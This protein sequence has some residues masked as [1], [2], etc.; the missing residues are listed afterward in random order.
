MSAWEEAAGTH[1]FSSYGMLPQEYI[2]QVGEHMLALVQALEPF[3]SDKEA[4]SLANEVM[5]GV[6]RVAQQPWLD[7]M[8][9][10]E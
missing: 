10:S 9:A 7:F 8:A 1:N 4:L 5:D 3:A 2:T 6:R